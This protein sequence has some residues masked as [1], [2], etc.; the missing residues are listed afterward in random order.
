MPAISLALST[1]RLDLELELGAEPNLVHFG[2]PGAAAWSA[3]GD[4]GLPFAVETA[5][6]PVTSWRVAASEV[7]TFDETGQRAVIRFESG[8]GRLVV[9]HH[10]LVF[11]GAT[12]VEQWQSIRNRAEHPVR[13]ERVDSFNLQLPAAGYELLSFTGDWGAEFE[14]V[15]ERLS[16]DTIIESTSGRSSKGNHPWFALTRDDGEILS[17]SVMW[18]GNWVC[19][20]QHSVDGLRISGGLHDR[21]FAKELAPGESM[22]SPHVAIALGQ[23]GDLDTISN[24]YARVGRRYWYA[25]NELSDSLPVEWNQWWS[26]E[27]RQLDEAVMHANVAKADELGI[28]VCTLDAGWFGPSDKGTH[29]YDYRGDWDLVNTE[30]FPN[31]VR[32]IA[33][34]VH[35]RGL[36][37]GIWCEIESLGVKASL[38]ATSPGFVATRGGERLGYV[39]FGNPDVRAWALETL[40]RMVLEHGADWIKLDFNLDPGAGCDRTDHGHGAGDGLY[41][42]YRGYY[43]V[44][45]DFRARYPEVYLENCSSG[46]L[47]VDLGILRN[48]HA[49]F[50]SDPEWP[51]HS[52]QL[53]W[54]ATLMLAPVACL[55]WSYCEWLGEHR[56]QKFNPRDPALQ[57]HQF[58]YYTR[59]GMMSAFGVS[60]RL[61]DL[62]DWV[63]MRLAQHIRVYQEI[64]RPFV[65]S[66]DLYRLTAQ[67]KRWGEGDRWAS[68][69]FALAEEDRH[70]LFVFRV[71]GAEQERTF[72]PRALD[73]AKSYT[74]RWVDT[75][76]SE[77]R[78]GADLMRNGLTFADLREEESALILVTAAD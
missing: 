45:A 35:A 76:R 51:E 40:E 21:E 38:A 55:R 5:A 8:D 46:G 56:A 6:G 9:E 13:I 39:C 67:T 2:R 75:D 25:R 7:E 41:E 66:A 19:R 23:G 36:T 49:T 18:S 33:D 29:W 31:R 74:L 43:Q 1:S 53:F 57:P 47:R 54:G 3:L 16:G 12:V 14:P 69:Q 10:T 44:L 62:P 26:Y 50:L 20:F 27:D 28:E 68:Y 30:R 73:P 15:R 48:T 60:Q 22:E 52:L 70:L 4:A 24:E 58:D 37:F 17:A 64:V 78:S 59:I 34:D 11:P 65:R 77:S 61:P 63:A 72:Y 71:P 32:P 42:H